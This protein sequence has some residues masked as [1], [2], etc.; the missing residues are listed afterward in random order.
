M[1]TQDNSTRCLQLPFLPHGPV[2]SRRLLLH[3][4]SPARSRRSPNTRRQPL[5][6]KH[7]SP[8]T[9][10]STTRIRSPKPTPSGAR[11]AQRRLREPATLGTRPPR[12]PSASLHEI[13]DRRAGAVGAVLADRKALVHLHPGRHRR[14]DHRRVGRCD[15]QQRREWAP[16]QQQQ[17]RGLW[18]WEREW[19]GRRELWE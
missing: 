11:A 16:K 1:Q 8:S 10:R 7:I 3:Q 12:G 18:A 5:R 15:P 13:H 19:T 4:H 14:G 6:P 17:Q 9:T 2:L